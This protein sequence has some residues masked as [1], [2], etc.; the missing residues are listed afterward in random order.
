MVFFFHW[1]LVNCVLWFTCI[2]AVGWLGVLLFVFVYRP[3]VGWACCYLFL[4]TGRWLAVRLV[5]VIGCSYCDLFLFTGRWLAASFGL[6]FF[7]GR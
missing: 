4:Y 1:P 5:R 2:L 7:T 3:L 6:F